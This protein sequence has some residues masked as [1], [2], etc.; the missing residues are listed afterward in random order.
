MNRRISLAAAVALI[1]I[2]AATAPVLAG[3]GATDVDSYTGCLNPWSGN[4]SKFALGDAPSTPC[5]GSQIE[6]HLGGGDITE[7][8]ATPEGG[9]AGGGDNGSVA[10]GLDTI[11]SARVRTFDPVDIEADTLTQVPL[12]R[13]VYD[14]GDLHTGSSPFITAPRDG[15]YVVT[16]SV[17]WC[18]RDDGTR[19]LTITAENDAFWRLAHSKVD[20]AANEP[21]ADS[22]FTGQSVTAV[23]FLREGEKVAM[24]VRSSVACGLI[25]RGDDSPVLAMAWLGP[26]PVP[27][28]PP[29]S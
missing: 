4:L 10:L 21:V 14:T 29:R 26:G 11:P 7:V 12:H 6:V 13:E 1:A 17:I 20:A 28:P 24:E 2:A 22:S 9:L 3:H 19:E 18:F 8:V 15:I 25:T 16:A 27:P 5:S 23:D